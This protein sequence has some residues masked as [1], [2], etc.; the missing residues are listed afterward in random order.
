MARLGADQEW[1]IASPD[2]KRMRSGIGDRWGVGEPGG[3]RTHDTGIK[4]PLL[5]H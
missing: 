3:I 2:P 5:C 4:S 1:V